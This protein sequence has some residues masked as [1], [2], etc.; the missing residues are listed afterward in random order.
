[1]YGW[2]RAVKG[3]S[4]SESECES[5]NIVVCIGPEARRSIHVQGEGSRDTS[6]GP[7]P[8]VVQS[9]GMRCG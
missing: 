8:L 7:H 6:G 9:E 2:L 5:A 1:M 3:W 4:Q